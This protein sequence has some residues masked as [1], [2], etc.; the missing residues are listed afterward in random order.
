[1]NPIQ[2]QEFICRYWGGEF[3]ESL[4]QWLGVSI[5]TIG[6]KIKSL[7][8]RRTPI[9]TP[10]QE[11]D[12]LVKYSA[13]ESQRALAKEYS[14][15]Q[16]NVRYLL[17]KSGVQTR[18]NY[19]GVGDLSGTYFNEIVTNAEDRKIE[20]GV[21]I[22]EIWEL[23]KLQKGLCRFTGMKLS[24]GRFEER[25]ASLDR[26]DSTKGYIL[27]NVQWVH[28]IVNMMKRSMT[29]DEFIRWC[30]AISNHAKLI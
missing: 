19:K 29:D 14:T 11:A 17:Q 22:E 1:M 12:I 7:G 13:G 18:S 24:L 21:S 26:I 4:A 28:K 20:I 8:L 23:F 2:E 3:R 27:G 30:G 9:F 6:R 16:A 15:S 25:T 10:I 5:A